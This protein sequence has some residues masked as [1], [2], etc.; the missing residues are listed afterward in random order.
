MA[1]AHNRPRRPGDRARVLR[2]TTRRLTCVAI[3]VAVTAVAAGCGGGDG[4]SGGGSAQAR[5]IDVGVLPIADVAPLYLGIRKGFFK[6]EG[7][8]VKPHT[9]G[10]GAAVVTGVVSGDFDFGFAATEPLILAK[11]KGLP[12]KIVAAGNQAAADPRKGWAMLMVKRNGP[13][14]T[15]K[16]LEGRTIATAALKNTNAL[17]TTAWLDQQGVDVSKIKFT[18]VGFPDQPAAVTQG[19]V[20]AAAAVEPFVTVLEAGQGRALGSYLAGLRPKMTI[21]TYFT[22]D[23]RIKE[24]ADL[25]AR[26]ARAMNRSLDYAQAHQ[27]EARKVILTYTKIPPEAVARIR[28]PRWSSDLNRPSIDYMATLADR[29]G[30]TGRKVDV[31]T[32]IWSGAG[33]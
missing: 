6:R 27:G 21:G 19:R 30:Y 31:S 16:D 5:S 4:G 33:R 10:G 13:I 2:G 28:L 20:A 18:E 9:V 17:T 23:Q 1:L 15:P 8:S 14:R 25:T 24:D 29:Y 32:L 11:D 26:F 3:A 22:L 7:L 12:V